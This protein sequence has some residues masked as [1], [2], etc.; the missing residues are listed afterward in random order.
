MFDAEV[1]D[2]VGEDRE[3]R[4]VIGVKLAAK[5]GIIS[6]EEEGKRGVLCDVPVDEE[7]SWLCSEEYALG[8]TTICAANPQGLGRLAFRARL[9]EVGR[10]LDDGISPLVVGSLEL[11]KHGVLGS[12][13]KSSSLRLRLRVNDCSTPIAIAVVASRDER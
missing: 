3:R 7:V 13:S 5:G 2:G 6:W 9:E 8:Y 4:I 12:H 1:L 11:R 10:D